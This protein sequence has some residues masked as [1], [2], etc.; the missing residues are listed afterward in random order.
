MVALTAKA[1]EIIHR[2]VDQAE[3]EVTGLRIIVDQGGCSGLQYMLGLETSART[4]DRIYDFGDVKVF[5]DPHSLPIIDGLQIDF[6][7]SLETSGFIFDNPNAR[8]VCSCGK[9]FSS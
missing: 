3:G 7:E 9:S 5:V 6:I 2:L 8:D 4:D 1:Q